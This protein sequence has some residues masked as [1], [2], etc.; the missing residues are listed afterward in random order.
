[1][2]TLSL[3]TSAKLRSL[4]SSVPVIIRTLVTLAIVHSI[5]CVARSPQFENAASDLPYPLPPAVPHAHVHGI[6]SSAH[7]RTRHACTGTLSAPFASPR[8]RPSKPLGPTGGRLR[9][10]EACT[11]AKTRTKSGHKSARGRQG[12]T[13]E[14]GAEKDGENNGCVIVCS[15]LQMSYLCLIHRNFDTVRYPNKILY[16]RQQRC[17]TM[18]DSA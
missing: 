14:D 12:W 10:R 13:S 2:P 15:S 4:P 7:A 8:T 11:E 17:T 6:A 1:M 5:A 3:A 18:A 9:T 16:R